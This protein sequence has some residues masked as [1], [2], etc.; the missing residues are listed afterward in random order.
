MLV[1]ALIVGALLF[2]TVAPPSFGQN[3]TAGAPPSDPASPTQPADEDGAPPLSDDADTP[4][5][6]E[7]GAEV[8]AGNEPE[9]NA[10]S[11]EPAPNGNAPANESA[12]APTNEPATNAEP[13]VDTPAPTPAPATTRTTRPA[14]RR[15]PTP[16]A[17]TPA[18]KPAPKPPAP[19]L[20]P[21]LK[22]V[23]LKSALEREPLGFSV[24][25][26]LAV[27]A[28]LSRLAEALKSRPTEA[29]APLT[30]YGGLI[31]VGLALLLGLV[32]LA[33]RWERR[34]DELLAP[35]AELWNRLRSP[36]ARG[37]LQLMAQSL[38]PALLPMVAWVIWQVYAGLALLS[39][40]VVL[41]ISQG[42]VIWMFCRAIAGVLHE[43][44]VRQQ[45]RLPEERAVRL[46]RGLRFALQL[47]GWLLLAVLVSE[48]SDYRREAGDITAFLWTLF[49]LCTGLAVIFALRARD[50]LW[51]LLPKTEYRA[52]NAVLNGFKTAFFPLLLISALV[53]VLQATG[54][55]QLALLFF[56]RGW[57]ILGTGL[58][59]LIFYRLGDRLIDE[60]LV[61]GRATE[62][63]ARR[64]HTTLARGLAVALVVLLAAG[65]IYI[66]DL[67][68]LIGVV[69]G[70]APTA[71]V[72]LDLTLGAVFGAI[73][74]VLVL[75][76]LGKVITQSLDHVVYPRLALE[77]GAAY[78]MNRLLVYASWIAAFLVALNLAGVP[79]ESMALVAGGLSVGI[80]LGL[81]DLAKDLANGLYLLLS[82]QVNKDDLI[83][84]GEIIGR[85]EDIGIRTTVVR[86]LSNKRML[87]TNSQLLAE[88]L[89]NWTLGDRLIRWDIP[90]GV[91]YNSDPHEVQ[92]V[93]LEAVAEAAYI[94][95]TPPP[96]VR[97]TAFGDSSLDFEL[98]AWIDY[99]ATGGG[100]RIQSDLHFLIW[101]VLKAHNIEIPFPQRDVHVRSAPGLAEFIPKPEAGPSQPP[102]EGQT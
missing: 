30:G 2:P 99:P 27:G 31:A 94:K 1:A 96:E 49:Y 25:T 12:N 88:P 37:L 65:T 83:N 59:A 72:G 74:T 15:Q 63:A 61:P 78:S 28:D 43:T 13:A 19:S 8:A 85:V 80:G 98:L 45:E 46:Y 10:P 7:N 53:L 84:V 47:G 91:S 93:V 60:C 5:A 66:L 71:G 24:E 16:Q 48:H 26:F 42:L 11:N 18:P 90:F 55:R 87:V 57:V 23:Q 86:S 81:Q 52:P 68:P 67:R 79:A 14:R 34:T 40:P 22:P 39:G 3:G 17:Q 29:L 44:L 6:P 38:K 82:R 92:R 69:S 35:E 51:V 54:F 20:L 100:H 70:Y 73:V 97:F 77:A 50:D 58:A 101:D 41:C 4:P 102:A 36:T 32:L 9:A 33:R 89:I 75:L 95:Q 62:G 56:T 21:R 64:L 76:W